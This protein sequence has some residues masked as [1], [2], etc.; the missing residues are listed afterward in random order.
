M[1]EY[2]IHFN[3][4]IHY[5]A[6]DLS[7]V[8]GDDAPSFV[9]RLL[10]ASAPDEPHDLHD[11]PPPPPP[12]LV[13]ARD[14]DSC[15]QQQQQQQQRQQE[16]SFDQVDH[17]SSPGHTVTHP[18]LPLPFPGA[19]TPNLSALTRPARPPPSHVAAALEYAGPRFVQLQLQ[20]Q[21]PA[22]PPAIDSLA[23]APSP[24]SAPSR[25]LLPVAP[26][27]NS[28]PPTA[29][30]DESAGSGSPAGLL[31][32]TITCIASVSEIYAVP[33]SAHLTVRTNENVL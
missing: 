2:Y 6:L 4:I 19:A 25:A 11:S 22:F 16:A 5:I 20:Q 7:S 18:S 31:Q 1:Y 28:F 29:A 33:V 8:F 14:R 30:R 9:R 15:Q 13:P 27:S 23:L 26:R 10:Q 17:A 32:V 21:Q 3:H 24:S 12:L